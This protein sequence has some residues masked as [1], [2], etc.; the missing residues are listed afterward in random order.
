[1]AQRKQGKELR[2][3]L[4]ERLMHYYHFLTQQEETA[5]STTFTSTQIAQM[6]HMDDTLVRKDLAAIG[7]RGMPRVGF[8]SSEVLAGIRKALGFDEEVRAVIIGAGRLGGAFASYAGFGPHGLEVCGLFDIAPQK[9]G[10]S[11]GRFRVEP[12]TCLPAAVREHDISIAIL[13]VPETAAQEVAGQAVAAGI[14]G[15]WNFASTN[16]VVPEDVFV[17]HEHISVGLAELRYNLMR[18]REPRSS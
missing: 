16:L 4:L 9:A 7:V 12:M 10:L 18:H 14:R 3:V 2:H 17:R 8:N 13:A 6:V 1:M 11:I 5:G 15:I